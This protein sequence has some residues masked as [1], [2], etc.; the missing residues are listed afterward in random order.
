MGITKFYGK[1]Q[2]DFYLYGQMGEKLY[3]FEVG[4]EYDGFIAQRKFE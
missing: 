1:I 2:N 4:K 3:V